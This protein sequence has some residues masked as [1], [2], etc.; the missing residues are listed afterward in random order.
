MSNQ[1]E[2]LTTAELD[3]LAVKTAKRVEMLEGLSEYLQRGA[4]AKEQVRH[5]KQRLAAIDAELD[6]R[7][8]YA[9]NEPT[10]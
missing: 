9:F 7:H 4:N 3:T 6:R 5:L 8:N 1:F 2:H 10:P